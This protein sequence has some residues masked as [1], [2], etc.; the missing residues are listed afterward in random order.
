MADSTQQRRTASRIPVYVKTKPPIFSSGYNAVL[1]EVR[2][3]REVIEAKE[4][5]IRELKISLSN[6]SSQEQQGQVKSTHGHGDEFS[7]TE[8]GFLGSQLRSTI[9]S[10]GGTKRKGI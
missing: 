7:E 6:D 5:R 3:K 9:F 1:K 2:K 4:T 10:P 8:S